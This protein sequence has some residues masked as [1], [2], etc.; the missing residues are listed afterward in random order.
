MVRASFFF[1][2]ELVLDDGDG[3]SDDAA[4][5]ARVSLVLEGILSTTSQGGM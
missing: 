2:S 5:G 4:I 1:S 3:F